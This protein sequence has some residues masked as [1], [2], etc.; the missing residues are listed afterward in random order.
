MIHVGGEIMASEDNK[1]LEGNL[2]KFYNYSF[3][4]YAVLATLMDE[5]GKPNIITLAWHSAVSIKPPMYG[6]S[7]DPRR[8]SH[9]GIL[10]NGE[11]VVNFCAWDIMDQVHYCGR[12]SGRKFDKFSETGLT[13]APARTVKV[14]LIAEAY[15]HLECKLVDH[16]QYG[17][18]TWFVGEV[19]AVTC[20][21]A[22]EDDL[23]RDE[24]E[25]LLYLGNN[26][27]TSL[28]RKRKKF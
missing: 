28:H 15:A 5:A 19:L 13:P 11:F 17:D 23:L 21:D 6:V 24:I 27:Y 3:P 14:P 16:H 25:P 4:K 8:Y 18:H 9:D 7:I 10:K 26:T 12:H 2:N 1:K 22:F 20:E